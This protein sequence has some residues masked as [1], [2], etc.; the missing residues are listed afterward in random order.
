MHLNPYG[1]DAVLFAAALANQLPATPGELGERCRDAGLVVDR[2]VTEDDLAVA[3]TVL[4]RWVAVVDTPEPTA[5]AARVNELL[6]EFCAH[7]RMTDH[8]GD[9]WHLHF[10]DHDLP[11]GRVLASLIGMGTALHLSGRGMHRL[12]RCGVEDCP[13]VFADVSRTG[14][15]RYCT[16]TCANRDAV[17]RHRAA[18]R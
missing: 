8:V 11:V 1:E 9:G 2:A 5:R 13:R 15:R 16:T 18:S 12:G 3:R 17:R 10:R 4:A 14:R 7:P 6:A